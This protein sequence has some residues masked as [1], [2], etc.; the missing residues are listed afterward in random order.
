M[1]SVDVCTYPVGPAGN[2]PAATRT[3]KAGDQV[4]LNSDAPGVVRA[5]HVT[6]SGEV[7]IAVMELLES[8]ATNTPT[9]GDQTTSRYRL[10][11]AAVCAV[12]VTPFGDV[13]TRC[14]PP[15]PTTT[16]RDRSGDQQTPDQLFAS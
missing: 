14:V 9:P 5:V 6:P 8:H 10:A 2:P 12:H 15:P 11:A 4:T 3:P 1:P 13:K 16:N 7:M